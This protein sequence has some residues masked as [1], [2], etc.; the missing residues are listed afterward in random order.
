MPSPSATSQPQSKATVYP[1]A[2][3]RRDRAELAE[4]RAA[5][6]PARHRQRLRNLRRSADAKRRLA[7][8]TVFGDLFAEDGGQDA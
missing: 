6:L 3:R 5:A 4:R 7:G 2:D 1:V 8:T